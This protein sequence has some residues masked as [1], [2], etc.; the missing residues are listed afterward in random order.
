M[1][2]LPS[3]FRHLALTAIGA[4]CL[5]CGASSAQI[6]A[7]AK[8]KAPKTPVA[9]FN[10][11]DPKHI[12]KHEQAPFPPADGVVVYE[13]DTLTGNLWIYQKVVQLESPINDTFS[14]YYN[15][16]FKD[17]KLKS[18]IAYNKDKKALTLA[19]VAPTDK[20]MMRVVHEGKLNIYDDRINYIYAPKDV[21]RGVITISYD[22][23]VEHLGSFLAANT[24]RDLIIFVN[25]IY[26]LHIDPTTLTWPELL[27][28]IDQLD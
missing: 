18:V 24:K 17:L 28:K 8:H 21:D 20:Y 19:R 26:Q 3:T 1:H 4:L 11:H 23:I 2:L 25:D 14:Y 13:D 10:P 15:F 5:C 9:G 7:T 6:A 12:A 27:V 22:G 16:K